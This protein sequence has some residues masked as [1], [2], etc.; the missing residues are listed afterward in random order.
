MKAVVTLLRFHWGYSI[1][2]GWG[3]AIQRSYLGIPPTTLLGAILSAYG[4]LNASASREMDYDSKL[5]G[6][7]KHVSELGILWATSA[8]LDMPVRSG[9]K[10][11]FF[12]GPYQSWRTRARDI[13]QSVHRFLS[14]VRQLFNLISVDYA[15]YY[16][17]RALALYV[18]RDEYVDK[19]ADLACSITR[20]GSKESIVW[21]EDVVIANLKP[22]ESGVARTLFALPK[23]FASRLSGLYVV[24][25]LPF[26]INVSEFS[27]WF[28]LDPSTDRYAIIRECVVPLYPIGV[29]VEEVSSD[30]IAMRIEPSKSVMESSYATSILEKFNAIVVPKGA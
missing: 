1:R 24:E 9:I 19:V 6:A 10:I 16:D 29:R 7:L 4:Y 23:Q 11:A 30:A 20:I 2:T 14:S 12:T 22:L 27:T 25:S 5:I 18:V 21:V 8:I 26:P 28:S 13:P 3:S 17:G 15:S